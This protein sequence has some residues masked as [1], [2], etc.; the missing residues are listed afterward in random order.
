MVTPIE[1]QSGEKDN[2]AISEINYITTATPHP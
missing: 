1:E 2:A